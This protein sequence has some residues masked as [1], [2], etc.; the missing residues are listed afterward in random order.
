M[1]STEYAKNRALFPFTELQRHRGRWVGF[2]P[3][4]R[5]LL[6]AAPT[7]EAL[8][9]QLQAAGHDAEQVVYEQVPESGEEVYAGGVEFLEC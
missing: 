9:A 3:D 8:R 2:S 1:I 4:G 7:L 6:A 5:R